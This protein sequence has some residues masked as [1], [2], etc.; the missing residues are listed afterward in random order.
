MSRDDSWAIVQLARHA[1]RP[2]TLDYIGMVFSEFFELHGD[3]QFADDPAIV[4]G[5]GYLDGRTVAVVGHQKGRTTQDRL[6]RRF[7]MARPEGYR[8]ALRV[9]RQ[10]EKFGFPLISFIDTPGADPSLEAEE[11]GVHFAPAG[12]DRRAQARR[13]TTPERQGGAR[14]RLEGGQAPKGHPQRIGQALGRRHPDA[15]AGEG[16]GADRHGDARQVGR[17]QPRRGEQRVDADQEFAGMAAALAEAPEGHDLL[18]ARQ[19]HARPAGRGVDPEDGHSKGRVSRR[20][21]RRGAG[22][23]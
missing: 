8:K 9:M 16:A 11:R 3:R 14:Q 1:N 5:V 17:A 2:F 6:T 10:A 4:S 21:G 12:L 7:G 18:P 20:P 13:G 15:H 19:R 23:P 22:T